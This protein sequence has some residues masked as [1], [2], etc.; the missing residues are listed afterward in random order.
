MRDEIFPNR[1]GMQTGKQTGKQSGTQAMRHDDGPSVPT[2]QSH[3]WSRH[4]SVGARTGTSTG[5]VES[6]GIARACTG[7]RVA[8][9][10]ARAARRCAGPAGPAR[11][12]GQAH[13][14]P[15]AGSRSA[16]QARRH[17]PP[18]PASLVIFKRIAWGR[19]GS[20]RLPWSRAESEVPTEGC[21]S[22][23]H[24]A[25]L[26]LFVSS[27]FSPHLGEPLR[28]HAGHST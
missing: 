25:A 2:Q 12:P 1:H 10:P 28:L 21:N 26:T 20:A 4:C 13:R 5:R 8:G 17:A 22:P 24:Y 9:R 7:F 3:S 11:P 6:T 18:P 27:L 14:S 15:S 19:D 23:S 16:Q